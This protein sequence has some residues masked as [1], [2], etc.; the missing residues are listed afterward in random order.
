METQGAVIDDEYH[1][2]QEQHRE[3]EERL[4]QFA[5]KPHLTDEEDLEEKRLKK[6]KL[7]IK[8]Q[9]EAILRRQ[10]GNSGA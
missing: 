1:K 2:L 9:M 8:D 10:R 4:R 7:A 5:A 3:H 6:E